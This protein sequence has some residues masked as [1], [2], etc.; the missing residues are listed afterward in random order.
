MN[1]LIVFTEKIIILFLSI[2]PLFILPKYLDATDFGII[3]ICMIINSASMILIDS[4]LG[5][6]LIKKNDI[7]DKDYSTVLVFNVFSAVIIYFIL[8][9]CSEM[10]AEFFNMKQLDE[11]IKWMALLIVINS[12]YIVEK[13]RATKNLFFKSQSIINTLSTVFYT[14]F[15]IYFAVEGYKYYSVIIAQILCFVFSAICYIFYYKNYTKPV[16][17]FSSLLKIYKYGGAFIISGLVSLLNTNII[18]LAVGKF[19]GLNT[20][21]LYNRAFSFNNVINVNAI[22]IIDKVLFPSLSK[23][24]NLKTVTKNA[25]GILKKATII[26]FFLITI[27]MI[28]AYQLVDF[29]LGEKWIEIVIYLELLCFASYGIVVNTI[30]RNIVKAKGE[31]KDIINFEVFFLLAL[32]F[33]VLPLFFLTTLVNVLII[34]SLVCLLSSLIFLNKIKKILCV[35]YSNVLFCLIPAV[36]PTSI[37]VFLWKIKSDFHIT[38]VNFILSST[39]IVFLFFAFSFIAFSS[40]TKE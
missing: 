21:G 4:G 29:I 8:Y 34:Y 19:Y 32:I 40:K 3:A 28:N 7:E 35:R 9:F 10:L 18:A 5:G 25:K 39:F 11:A 17:Y 22:G 30:L 24:D 2:I 14:L 27:L 20:L 23:E 6:A 33:L 31:V 37:S 15:V 12:V 1:Y 36:V 13:V 16:F 26:S 38:N